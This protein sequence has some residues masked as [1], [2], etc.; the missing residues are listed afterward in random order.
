MTT[1]VPGAQPAAPQRS[2]PRPNVLAYPSPTTS[3][4]IVFLAALLTA[5]AFVGGWVHNQVLGHTWV[6]TV[7]HCQ[8]QGPLVQTSAGGLSGEIRRNAV[9]E[10]CRASVQRRG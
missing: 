5:G 10:R 7:I 9:E 8:Q 1:V 4:F 3:R 2:G 6:R